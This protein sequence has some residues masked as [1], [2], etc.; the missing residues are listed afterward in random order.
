MITLTLS[1]IKADVRASLDELQ[2]NESYMAG[3]QDKD[4]EDLDV[5]IESRALEALRFVEKNAS[6]E[7]LGDAP[8]ITPSEVVADGKILKITVPADMIRFLAFKA[9]DSDYF[10]TTL[11]G[12]DSDEALKQNCEYTCGTYERPA[13]VLHKKDESNNRILYYSLA[14]PLDDGETASSR[15]EL[16][17][18]LANPTISNDSVSLCALVKMLLLLF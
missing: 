15:I 13:M 17:S 4:N 12:S 14:S 10:V 2:P 1:N 18:Y 5:I 11:I 9:T 16:L 7:L 3:I 6:R 8:V